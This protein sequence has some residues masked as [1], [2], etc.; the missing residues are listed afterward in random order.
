MG[1][2]ERADADFEKCWL[3]SSGGHVEERGDASDWNESL[4]RVTGVTEVT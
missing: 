2:T 1:V 4:T 3:F